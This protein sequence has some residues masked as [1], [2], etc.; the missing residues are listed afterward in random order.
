MIAPCWQTVPTII[1]T[2]NLANILIVVIIWS[3]L[4]KER[5]FG[6]KTYTVFTPCIFIATV[7]AASG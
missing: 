4:S 2:L 7:S 6:K 5:A 3:V 1:E